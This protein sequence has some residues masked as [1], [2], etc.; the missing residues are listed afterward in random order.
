MRI[1]HIVENLDKGAVENWLV[2]TFIESRKTRP[3]WKWTFY[4]ILGKKGRL[5]EKVISS[6]GRII[7]SPH[8]IS[9]KYKFLRAFRNAVKQGHYDIIHSH[10]DFL[11]GFYLVA[12]AGLSFKKRILHVHN[13]DKALPVGGRTL[14]KILLPILHKSALWFSDLVIGISKDTLK[15][16]L[17]SIKPR[18]KTA[19]LYYGI[20]L[21]PFEIEPGS[22]W[23]KQKLDI[24]SDA[25][26]LLFVGRMNE[27]KNPVFLVDIL[28]ELT[29][30]RPRS[31]A[32]FVGKGDKEEA[33]MQRAEILGVADKIRMLGWRDDG[34]AIMKSSDLF[35]FPRVE[36]PKEGL[37][38]V[39]V[40]AQAAG[41]PMILSSGIVEDA[42]VIDQLAHTI[43]LQE[44]AR[45][46]ADVASRVLDASPPIS[47]T[48]AYEKMR[49]S[50]FALPTAT[51]HLIE[52]YEN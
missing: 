8:W 12:I 50:K 1:L 29:V 33:V 3:D 13:T 52:L 9:S 24:P 46:W 43:S 5:D 14:S 47:R 10:H 23:L 21:T 40:E 37:G 42:I 7:Y 34:P 20:D 48:E 44:N 22:D 17:P 41:L 15:E 38:L 6:G 30:Q 45:E 4:C 32:V 16:F 2:N 11:S 36:Y 25:S 27:L 39:V 49:V 51:R 35:I 31:Y 28:K 26:I 18:Y 19:V